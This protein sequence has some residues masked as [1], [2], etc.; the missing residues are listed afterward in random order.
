MLENVYWK[1]GKRGKGEKGKG[2]GKWEEKG[3]SKVTKKKQIKMK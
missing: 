1:N 3:R 2:E